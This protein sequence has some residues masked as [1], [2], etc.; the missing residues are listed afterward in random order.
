MLLLSFH[1]GSQQYTVS[2]KHI[3]EILP[4]TSVNL[5][6]NA[7]AY[8]A[9]L[10]D[11]RGVSVPVINLCQ[12]TNQHDYNR[13]LSSR[14]IIVNYTAKNRKIYPLGLIAEKVTETLNIAEQDFSSSG[15][16]IE[17]MSF[18]GGVS[19]HNGKMIQ[20]I[21]INELLTEQVQSMLFKSTGSNNRNAKQVTS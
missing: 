18:L 4:L 19:N 1:I 8:V 20:Y 11:Y 7:P 5:I 9:G 12:L 14:I 3:V 2:A 15:I 10:L 17:A 6:P 21:E 13:V 16:S